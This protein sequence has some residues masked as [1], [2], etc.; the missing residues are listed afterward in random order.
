MMMSGSNSNIRTIGYFLLSNALINTIIYLL[1]PTLL[2]N[3]KRFYKKDLDIN[4]K[5]LYLMI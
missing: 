1:S 3:S 5:V 4:T 2:N